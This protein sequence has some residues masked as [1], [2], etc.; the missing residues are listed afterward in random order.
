MNFNRRPPEYWN[1][2]KQRHESWSI[3]DE[4]IDPLAVMGRCIVVAI[5]YN[6]ESRSA[7]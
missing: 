5:Y 3:Y 7:T 1:L 6:E 4:H 2:I